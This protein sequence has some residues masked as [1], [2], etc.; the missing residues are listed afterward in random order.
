M[1][2]GSGFCNNIFYSHYYHNDNFC[3]QDFSCDTHGMVLER[4]SYNWLY[5][6]V[7]DCDSNNWD[8]ASM[9]NNILFWGV[10]KV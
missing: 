10:R 4:N 5:I 7:N 8:K 2:H 6:P 9:A 1:N 3:N